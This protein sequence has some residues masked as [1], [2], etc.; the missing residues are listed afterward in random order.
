MSDQLYFTG[1]D[2]VYLIIPEFDTN[3]APFAI[4]SK[5][6]VKT[7]AVW[8]PYADLPKEKL[9]VRDVYKAALKLWREYYPK[10]QKWD[11]VPLMKYWDPDESRVSLSFAVL[12][13]NYNL[14]N[15]YLKDHHITTSVKVLNDPEALKVMKFSAPSIEY[16]QILHQNLTFSKYCVSS[17]NYLARTNVH[18]LWDEVI[19]NKKVKPSHREIGLV[20]LYKCRE[21]KVA[22]A[23]CIKVMNNANEDISIR[24]QAAVVLGD[25]LSESPNFHGINKLIQLR[26]SDAPET[27]INYVSQA[28]SEINTNLGD[29]MDDIHDT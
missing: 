15:I 8:F 24:V 22:Q 9:S 25:L 4:H 20:A 11:L 28:L 6:N 13:D 10:G 16:C 26:I 1:V 21:I 5:L 19:N 17:L 3:N 2:R 7:G 14:T 27:L 23:M 29:M 18:K 12:K